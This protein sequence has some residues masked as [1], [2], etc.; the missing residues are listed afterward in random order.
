MIHGVVALLGVVAAGFSGVFFRDLYLNRK[1]LESQTNFKMNIIFGFVTDFFDTLGIGN[2]APTTALFKIFRQVEDRV[3]PGTLNVSHTIPVVLEAFLFMTVIDV[4]FITLLSMI[5]SAIFGAVIGAGYVVRLPERK[6]QL[7]MGIALIITGCFMIFGQV[8]L[9]EDLGTGEAIGLRGMKLA[10]GISVNFV[11]GALMTIGVGLYAPCM[12]LV[13][14]L[15]LSPVVA[16]PIMM[17]SCAFL[18]PPASVKFI[19]AGAYNRKAALGITIG[20]IFGVLIAVYLVKS[21]P[22][23][24]LVW[25]VICVVFITAAALIRAAILDQDSRTQ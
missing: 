24:I 22:L 25:L 11:L 6:V 13:Y 21:L 20:G 3:L 8:G 15:G 10:I 17:G 9:I 5:L 18:M 7:A 4:D 2:F 12:A 1:T 16:F 19:R 23:T 14:M